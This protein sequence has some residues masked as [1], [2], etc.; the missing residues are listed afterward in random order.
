V[1]SATYGRV[2]GAKPMRTMDL[3]LRVVF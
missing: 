3:N 1:N 2:S